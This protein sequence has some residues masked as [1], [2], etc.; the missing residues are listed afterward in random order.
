MSRSS[1]INKTG[2]NPWVVDSGS[3]WTRELTPER[4]AASVLPL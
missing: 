2:G 3:V 4:P 1:H